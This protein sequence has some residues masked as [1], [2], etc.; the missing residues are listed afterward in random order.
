MEI[1][2][3]YIGGQ[4]K[5][6][7]EM[8]ESLFHYTDVGAVK[9][10]LEKRELWLT[11]LR[12]LNDAQELNDGVVYISDALRKLGKT[13]A[14][15]DKYFDESISQLTS[16]FDDHISIWIDDEPTF[17]CS[18]SSAGN[19]LSQWRAYGGYAIEFDR[20]LLGSDLELFDCVYDVA[21]KVEIAQDM[22]S[23]AIDG[24]A[25][26]FRLYD[27]L[28]GP[29]SLDFLTSL[30]RTASI[31]KNKSFYEERE[32]RCVVDLSIPHK[33]L[34]FR[35]RGNILVPYT[36]ASFSLE[37]VKAIHIGPMRDQE[38]AYISMIA[39]VSLLLQ[40]FVANGGSIEHEIAIVK[41]DIPYRAQ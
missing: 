11:D 21:E 10:I 41:S 36:I 35:Q 39:L 1:P 40:D 24:L 14:W 29:D 5:W 17:V 12:F 37:C 16:S 33:N 22:V 34:R 8:S 18:F 31:F 38:L 6:S 25:A 2:Q 9:A 26:D 19:Q 7:E 15:R 30:I 3:R 20:E 13:S 23:T 27:G 4:N 32:V 28:A